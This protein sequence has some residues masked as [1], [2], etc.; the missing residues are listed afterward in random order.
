M[1]KQFQEEEW[2]GRYIDRCIVIKRELGEKHAKHSTMLMQEA[3]A[4]WS[5]RC[6]ATAQ[7]GVVLPYVQ[8]PPPP[9]IG[10]LGC[11]QQ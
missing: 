10:A 5:G 7:S 9:Q 3:T 6:P 11:I 1:Q 2:R 4:D 8:S